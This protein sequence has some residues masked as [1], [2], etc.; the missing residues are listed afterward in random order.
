MLS[1]T[2]EYVE[3]RAGASDENHNV[4]FDFTYENIPAKQNHKTSYQDVTE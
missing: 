4:L 1:T 3:S 2:Q